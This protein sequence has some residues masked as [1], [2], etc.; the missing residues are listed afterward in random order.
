MRKLKYLALLYLVVPTI[1]P[2]GQGYIGDSKLFVEGEKWLFENKLNRV[3]IKD[4]VKAKSP[5]FSLISDNLIVYYESISVSEQQSSQQVTKAIA[6]G[7][8]IIDLNNGYTTF[9][10]SAVYKKAEATFV[11]QG[12]VKVKSLT[13]EVSGCKITYQIATE[14]YVIEECE[15]QKARGKIIIK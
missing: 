6:E 13:N 3:T 4:K 14:S 11:L 1:C 8:V 2:G 12:N 9:S 15:D 10:D 5:D 7:E